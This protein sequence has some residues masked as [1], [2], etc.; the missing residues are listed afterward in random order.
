MYDGAGQGTVVLV[1]GSTGGVTDKGL[2]SVVIPDAVQSVSLLLRIDSNEDVL[3]FDNFLVTAGNPSL[4]CGMSSFG[5]SAT[6]ECAAFTNGTADEYTLSL[7]YSGSDAN[8][9]LALFVDGSPA[10]A[11]TNN[12]DEPATTDDG[13]IDLS[14]PDLAEGTS[15]KVTFTDAGGS[16][17]YSVTA[18]LSVT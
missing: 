18:Y 4:P 15:Y 14:S 13:T 8:G 10:S 1:D 11:F 7:N 17:A 2:V 6:A 16:C 3:A 9:A 5:P 12:G